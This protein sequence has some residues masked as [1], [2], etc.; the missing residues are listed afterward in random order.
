MR[1]PAVA[2]GTWTTHTPSPGGTSGRRNT[3][4]R[5]LPAST[6][7]APRFDRDPTDGPH[8][9][10]LPRLSP[11]AVA[12]SVNGRVDLEVHFFFASRRL[13]PFLFVISHTRVL[14]VDTRPNGMK[15]DNFPSVPLA[16]PVYPRTRFYNFPR[17][18]IM[19]FPFSGT[20]KVR[21]G[22][23][24]DRNVWKHVMFGVRKQFKHILRVACSF[25]GNSSRKMYTLLALLSERS[26]LWLSPGVESHYVKGNSSQTNKSSNRYSMIDRLERAI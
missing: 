15:D 4:S 19:E 26:E 18:Q 6:T 17:V 7:G 20:N 1:T 11:S 21:V 25:Y 8:T 9:H 23:E 3:A 13:K 22:T 24:T 16:L 10:R 12:R 14:P 5:T 2:A